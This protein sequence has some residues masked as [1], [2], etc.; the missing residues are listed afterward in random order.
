[1]LTFSEP[2]VVKTDAQYR[3]YLSEIGQ[4]MALDPELNSPEGK[5]L[6]LLA[7]LTETYEK[8]H[9]CIPLPNPVDAILFRLE[10]KGLQHKDLIPLIGTKGR[11]SEVL[12]GKRRLT[13]PMVRK[14]SSHL[15][16]PVSIL[17]GEPQPENMQVDTEP[18]I[19]A[20]REIVKRGWLPDGK[21]IVTA[22]N[23]SEFVEQ[24]LRAVGVAEPGPAYF[25]RSIHAG[26]A[27]KVNLNTIRLWIAQVLIRSRS[28]DVKRGAFRRE[29]F[30]ENALQELARLSWFDKGPKLALEYLSKFGI[31]VVVEKHLPGTRVDGAAVLDLD[32]TPV[33]G[34][35]LRFDRLDNFWFTLLHECVHVIKHLDAPG[36]TFVDDTEGPFDIDEKEIEANR[37]TRDSL[38]PQ[39]AWRRSDASRLKSVE[40]IK[41]LAGELRIHPA[42]VAGR[43]RRE[44]GNY[45]L[46][47]SLVGHG[48]VKK[49]LSI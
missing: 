44:T 5:R 7:L 19:S 22:K 32:G 49:V 9:F 10:Q 2:A 39:E 15:D 12:S 17:I 8:E 6:E 31:A 18:P 42:I 47:S 34:L 24:L 36:E 14:L 48:L 38:I 29:A 27:G 21:A 25:R 1:M 45:K 4:L 33:I 37:L 41:A 35:T 30:G 20:V 46:L 16:I 26:I 13:V 40:A 11:V 3:E 28:L 43:I 23:A